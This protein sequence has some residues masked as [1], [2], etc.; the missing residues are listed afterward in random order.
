MKSK[1]QYPEALVWNVNKA[2]VGLVL[3]QAET[4]TTTWGT[5][6]LHCLSALEPQTNLIFLG[7]VYSSESRKGM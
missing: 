2:I 6:F 1:H 7:S 4:F 5:C 3:R